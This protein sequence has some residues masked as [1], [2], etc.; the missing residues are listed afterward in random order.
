[1]ILGLETHIMFNVAVYQFTYSFSLLSTKIGKSKRRFNSLN[2]LFCSLIR[3]APC[4]TFVLRFTSRMWS[5]IR[6]GSL[7]YVV[8]DNQTEKL[9]ITRTTHLNRDIDI[10][11]EECKKE[12]CKKI[13]AKCWPFV[14]ASMRW[15]LW[16]REWYKN[17]S[18]LIHNHL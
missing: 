17:P 5:W 4:I 18:I 2:Y 15:L 16:G 12:E 1:M 13:S 9:K 11:V 14:S 3:L 7:I 10:Y 8:V 6:C